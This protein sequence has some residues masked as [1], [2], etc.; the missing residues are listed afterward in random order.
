MSDNHILLNGSNLTAMSLWRFA[1]QAND[2]NFFAKIEICPES[3][4]RIEASANY[5][6]EICEGDEAVYGINT[7]FGRFAEVR[8]DDDELEKLQRN[9]ILSHC[10][11]TGNILKRSTVL[12]MWLNRLNVICRGHTG[13][14]LE[15][16]ERIIH[17]L[18]KGF[19]A[20]VPSRG[21]VGASGDLAP[22]AHA[23]IVYIGEGR[24]S[25]PINGEF[26]ELSAEEALQHLEMK[27]LKL[28]AKEGLALIN[29]TQL[30]TV[31]ACAAIEESQYL[32]HMANTALA[33]SMEATRAS[34]KILDPRIHREKNQTGALACALE[35]YEWIRG[36]TEISQSH[37]DCHKV[38]D[39]YSFRCAP[40]VHGTFWDD[41]EDCT[42]ILDRE[43]NSSTDNPLIFADEKRSVSGGNFHALYPAK[44]CDRLS[45]GLCQLMTISE[46]RLSASMNSDT[47]GLPTFLINDGGLNSGFM[48]AQVTAAALCGEAKSM[49][50][51][52]SVDTIPTN[53]DREDHVSMGPAAGF[54]VQHILELARPVLAIELLAGA[55]ALDLLKPLQSSN[56][57]KQLHQKIRE[58][59]AFL[60]HDRY[61][62]DDIEA[63]TK[64]I[65]ERKL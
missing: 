60:D 6:Q 54:K 17:F 37:R 18:E 16:V 52:A 10:C 21:S 62:A 35:S 53:D 57:L 44:V 41:I 13:V 2:P 9:I 34:H 3:K 19:L 26:K 32:L 59:S 39:P 4:K 28:A 5:V 56:P 48:M 1:R 12:A 7:G 20:N 22:S 25:I 14:R 61:L 45:I 51:P 64:L 49:A 30:S 43:L 33:L 36:D 15:T 50:H 55:Q 47:T 40:L 63:M 23:T 27:P 29:G 24:G 38:Q 46:R 58:H 42:R 31:L 65:N 11:G 8:I